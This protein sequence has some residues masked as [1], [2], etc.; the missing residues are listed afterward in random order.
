MP[1]YF[2]SFT[3]QELK[4]HILFRIPVLLTTLKTPFSSSPVIS[5]C[6]DIV[7]WAGSTSAFLIKISDL[8]IR[9]LIF[10]RAVILAC[11]RNFLGYARVCLISAMEPKI[12]KSDLVSCYIWGISARGVF[13]WYIS[14]GAVSVKDTSAEGI[15]ENAGLSSIDF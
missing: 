1:V 2:T 12:A 8:S 14:L 7:Y 15:C 4:I 10:D 9:K 13:V 3:K 6:L 11:F 5:F